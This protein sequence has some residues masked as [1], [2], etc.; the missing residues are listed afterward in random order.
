MC[1]APCNVQLSAHS[2]AL[3][4]GSYQNQQNEHPVMGMVLWFR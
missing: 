4:L 1:I 2:L 3:R